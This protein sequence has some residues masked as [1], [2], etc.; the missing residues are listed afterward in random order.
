MIVRLVLWVSYIVDSY[1]HLHGDKN[2][3]KRK[4]LIYQKEFLAKAERRPMYEGNWWKINEYMW[5]PVARGFSDSYSTDKYSYFGEVSTVPW[6]VFKNKSRFVEGRTMKLS[7]IWMNRMKGRK[8]IGIVYKCCNTV[9]DYSLYSKTSPLLYFLFPIYQW[10]NYIYNEAMLANERIMKTTI[11]V[12]NNDC[13]CN[14]RGNTDFIVNH[15]LLTN[16]WI[17]IAC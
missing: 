5:L 6:N 2:T 16:G 17:R 11:T 8:T 4:R 7:E 12:N 13:P 9:K 14:S 3:L 1:R 15:L 10:Y